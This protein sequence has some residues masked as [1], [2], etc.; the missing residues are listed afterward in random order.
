MRIL[1]FNSG[2]S[3]L[4]YKLFKISP[5]GKLTV[6]RYGKA[7]RVGVTGSV[8]SF[9]EY[10]DNQ[11]S[12]RMEI[13]IPDHRTAADLV[14]AHLQA[15]N[16]TIDA[17]GHRFVHGGSAFQSTTLLTPETLERLK[18][19]LPL[20]PIHNPNS[21]SV[22]ETCLK[23][24][25]DLPEYLTFDTAFHATLPPSAYTYAL[26]HE[27]VA[28][29]GLR[30][31]GFHGLSYQYVSR[32]SAR[33]L[34]LSLEGLR[35]VACHL[36][37]GGSSVAAILSGQSVDT[38]MGYSPLAGLMMSTRS[39]D[40][41]ALLPLYLERE[42]G[43]AP[44]ELE[45]MFNKQSGLL[46]ISGFSS[47]IRDVVKRMKATREERASLAFMLYIQHLKKT[48]G[49]YAALLG[50]IDVLVFTDIIGA[51]IWRV[52]QAACEGLEWCGVL[53]DTNANRHAPGDRP[54]LISAAGARARIVCIPTDE[55]RIIAEEGWQLL[56][57]NNH[58]AH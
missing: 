47:D 39:G 9:I 27:L 20:A 50:G 34:G 14:L 35:M 41:D 19:T 25:P 4:N 6:D 18:D 49:A 1:V 22:I 11:H 24:L 51:S 29:Y 57:E 40:L 21:M 48:I 16:A 32:A 44:A 7:H 28:R 23:A 38:S 55:E 2:S 5:G 43:Y 3:S 30:R 53:L 46:G 10:H 42:L 12:E 37:T 31:Y 33:F 36:G 15:E 17:I 26:P 45:M 13:P 8:P 56:L 52:R 54:A 58:A